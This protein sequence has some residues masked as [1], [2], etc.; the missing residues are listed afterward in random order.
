MTGRCLPQRRHSSRS[1]GSD[2]SVHR[3]PSSWTY[4]E[5]DSLANGQAS[6]VP[7]WLE[8]LDSFAAAEAVE[9]DEEE[10]QRIQSNAD[11]RREKNVTREEWREY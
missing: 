2:T 1:V 6:S 8:F 10:A 7:S 11:G 5:G 9:A 3:C 4:N